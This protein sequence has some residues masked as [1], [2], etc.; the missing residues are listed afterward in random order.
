MPLPDF[1]GDGNQIRTRRIAPVDSSPATITPN[2]NNSQQPGLSHTSYLLAG[3]ELVAGAGI[4]AVYVNVTVGT[5]LCGE[6]ALRPLIGERAIKRTSANNT[7]PTITMTLRCYPPAPSIVLYSPVRQRFTERSLARS[8]A[9]VVPEP[10]AKCSPR[11][12]GSGRR[13][14]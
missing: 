12:S 11:R 5:R 10:L 13:D 2:A 1:P 9:F 14:A 8:P 7:Q 6:V 4:V 3:V